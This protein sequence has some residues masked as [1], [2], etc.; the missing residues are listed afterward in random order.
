M[1][2]NN[3]EFDLQKVNYNLRACKSYLLNLVLKLIPC[4]AD[5][6]CR[7]K[8]TESIHGKLEMNLFCQQ[9]I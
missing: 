7:E 4:I 6:K 2:E 5:L 9:I 8:E 1:T 3:V